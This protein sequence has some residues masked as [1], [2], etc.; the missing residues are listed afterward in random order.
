[1]PIAVIHGLV[2]VKYT[3]SRN[4]IR[5]VVTSYEYILLPTKQWQPPL[6]DHPRAQH[7]QSTRRMSLTVKRGVEVTELSTNKQH[8]LSPSTKG[9]PLQLC[10][11][12]P[13]PP[14][15][16]SLPRRKRMWARFLYWCGTSNDSVP[17][18][19]HPPDCRRAP[20][21]A[22]AATAAAVPSALPRRALLL[23]KSKK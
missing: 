6:P 13:P 11:P 19:A 22:F 10:H 21:A 14:P 9:L 20:A 3:R 8:N 7:V 18:P 2:T 15:P 4:G 17:G 1:L 5:F 16:S 23:G 12:L